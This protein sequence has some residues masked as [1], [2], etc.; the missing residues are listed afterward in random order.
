MPFS[1]SLSARKFSNV[2]PVNSGNGVPPSGG[3]FFGVLMT[4]VQMA[5]LIEVCSVIIGILLFIVLTVGAR[6]FK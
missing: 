1:P 5:E 2:S 3:T 4:E 6:W